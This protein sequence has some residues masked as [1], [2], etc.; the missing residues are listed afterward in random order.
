VKSCFPYEDGVPFGF[1]DMGIDIGMNVNS[2]AEKEYDFIYTGSVNA[3]RKISHVVNRFLLPDMAGRTLLILSRDYEHFAKE[4]KHYSNIIFKGPFDREE[5]AVYLNRSRFAINYIP[6]REPFNQQTS[7]KF[8][9]YQQLGLPVITTDYTWLRAFE[10]EY[11]GQF[12][13]IDHSLKNLQWEQLNSFQFQSG[14]LDA[15]SW[16]KQIEGSGVM[17]FLESRK[18]R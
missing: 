2:D 13:K 11:G 7:T 17:K 10:K 6:D 4:Y 1:R 14:N 12:F 3:D 18:A 9:E 15:W 8:L 5:L 16:E